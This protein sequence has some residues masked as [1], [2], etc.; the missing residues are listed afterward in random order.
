MTKCCDGL[1]QQIPTTN[2]VNLGQFDY[3]YATTDFVEYFTD[4]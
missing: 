4:F 3:N 2:G 1:T